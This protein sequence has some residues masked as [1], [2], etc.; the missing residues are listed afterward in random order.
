M[1]KKAIKEGDKVSIPVRSTTE[2]LASQG[3][4]SYQEA[5]RANAGQNLKRVL[6]EEFNNKFKYMTALPY[7]KAK[8]YY[9]KGDLTKDWYVEFY[10]L[11]P[12]T[13]DKFHRFKERFDINRY[14][15][16]RE[17]YDYGVSLTNFLNE[18]LESGWNPFTAVRKTELGDFKICS[19][20]T[21]IIN[22]LSVNATKSM[23]ASYTD[24]KNRFERYLTEKQLTNLYIASVTVEHGR[25]FKKWALHSKGL[26]VKT[27]NNT[28]SHLAMF[29]DEAIEMGMTTQNPFKVLPK[30]KKRD[31]IES[32]KDVRFEPFTD[33]EM[34]QVFPWLKEQ[35]YEH[36][37]DFLCIIYYAF[38]RPIE[39]LRLRVCDIEMDRS[40]IRFKKHETKND[41]AAYVQIVPPLMQVFERMDLKQYP[42]DY[43]LFSDGY[44]PGKRMFNK[45]NPSKLWRNTVKK[46]LKVAK[47][48]YALKHTGN[49]EY[50]LKNKGNTNLKWQQMQNRHS[51]SAITDRYNRKLGAY[52]I[53]VGEI[54]FR[55]ID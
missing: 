8:L 12:G 26:A 36:F 15:T 20:L 4:H 10:Y 37:V 21:K 6:L 31:A 40:L 45:S 18:K 52:F 7:K 49:I 48:M 46:D 34:M 35:G 2:T 30:A 53:E 23:V 41:N 51:S 27:V 44:K 19:Q 14:K 5:S 17:R 43:Y 47:D 50:L 16:Y 39:I 38:A 3:F 29:F 32:T 24:V 28:L 1:G 13:I 33:K 42:P 25:S 22:Q 54:N 11:T 9:A 55:I